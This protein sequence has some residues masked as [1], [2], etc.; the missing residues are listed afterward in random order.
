MKAI[1]PWEIEWLPEDG[2]RISRLRFAGKDLL[3]RP[4][5]H[6]QA[7]AAKWGEYERRPVYGY[8]DCFPTVDPSEPWPDHGELC[9]LQWTGDACQASVSSRLASLTFSRVLQPLTDRL[10]WT[11][12]ATNHS[13]A[14]FPFQHAMHPLVPLDEICALS[15]PACSNH[16]TAELSS[17]FLSWPKGE[18]EMFYLQ[19][20]RDGHVSWSYRDGPTVHLEFDARRFPTLGIWWNRDGYPDEEGCRRNE[21]AF[22]PISGAD[23]L[24]GHGTTTV[25][26]PGGTD[27]WTYTWRIS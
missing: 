23:S 8:D 21:A 14:P 17:R 2:G 22:E 20:I 27:R 9:W 7:P 18:T 4:P 15:L 1:G 11:F 10:V 19:N 24:L 25:L 26:P 13:D 6:F 16:E 12:G 5:L 3:T